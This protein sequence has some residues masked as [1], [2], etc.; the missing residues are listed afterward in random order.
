[1]GGPDDL[2]R[3]AFFKLGLFPFRSRDH[4]P[5]DRNRHSFGASVALDLFDQATKIRPGFDLMILSVQS[6]R[7]KAFFLGTRSEGDLLRAISP[8][9]LFAR[10]TLPGTSLI[11]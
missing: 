8:K 7:H 6:D 1:L 11:R 10:A 5:V 4:F 3:T 9:D 2:H